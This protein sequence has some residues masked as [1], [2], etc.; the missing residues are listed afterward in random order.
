M[1]RR[2][3]EDN[4]CPSTR[5]HEVLGGAGQPENS[6]HFAYKIDGQRHVAAQGDKIGIVSA[7]NGTEITGFSKV[8]NGSVV[9]AQK[10][11]S[12]CHVMYGGSVENGSKLV[13]GNLDRESFLEFF[14]RKN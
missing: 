12:S 1:T 4:T 8:L 3:L 11:Q 9:E 5:S 13:N 6:A 14:C 7:L 2:D 10:S